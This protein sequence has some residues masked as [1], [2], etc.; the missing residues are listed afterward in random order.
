M[1]AN[2][3][4]EHCF[5]VLNVKLPLTVRFKVFYELLEPFYT[6][7][8]LNTATNTVVL[9]KMFACPGK[10]PVNYVSELNL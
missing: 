3:V 10:E 1:S 9:L 6:R 8:A 4:E 7:F 5:V 2:I